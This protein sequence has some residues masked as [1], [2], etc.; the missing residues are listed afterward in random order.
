[1]AHDI[2]HNRNAFIII[3]ICPLNFEGVLFTHTHTH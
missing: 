2:W 3:I 1:M